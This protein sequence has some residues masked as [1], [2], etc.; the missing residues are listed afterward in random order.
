MRHT[1][2]QFRFD[3]SR[4]TK[5]AAPLGG[6]LALL[7]QFVSAAVLF[8]T[9]DDVV[10]KLCLV[11][12]WVYTFALIVGVICVL[13]AAFKYMSAGGEAEKVKSAHKALTFA[14]IGI[15]VAIL[16]AGVP[17]VVNSVLGGST[18]AVNVCR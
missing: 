14:V 2:P 7:P 5:F 6:G 8:S 11:M 13:F 9:V 10:K 18:S 4:F 1:I 16:A 15:T 3:S 17:Y 12:Q